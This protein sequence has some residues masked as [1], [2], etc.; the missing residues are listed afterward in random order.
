MA[1]SITTQ[2]FGIY[3]ICLTNEA[4][5]YNTLVFE[6]RTGVQAKD[7]A[8]HIENS[9]Y[10]TSLDNQA[11]IAELFISQIKEENREGL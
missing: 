10:L 8:S 9:D 7:Y 5:R 3:R 6:F 2:K 11:K 1:K 4:D